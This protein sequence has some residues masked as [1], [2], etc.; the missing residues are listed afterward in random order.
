MPQLILPLIPLGGTE[1]SELVNI[2]REE[3]I[4]TYFVS[5]QPIFSH[6]ADDT[7]MFRLITSQLIDSG[8]C[9]Q[10]DILN[11]FGISKSSVDRSLKTLREKGADAFF[12]SRQRRRGGTKLTRNVLEQAQIFLDQGRSRQEIADHLGIKND[13]LRKAIHDGRLHKQEH[14]A[15]A[16]TKS[17]RNRV[18]AVA[19]DGMGTACTRV[20]ERVYASF[21][22][23]DGAPV[24]FESCLDVPNG[25]VMCA[26]P[27]LLVNGLLDGVERLSDKIKGYYTTFHILLLLAFMA[28]CRIKTV[29]KLKRQAPGEFG[30]LLGLDRIP[31]VRCL[32]QKL[33]DLSDGQAVEKW[34][35][36][37]S[38]YWMES[39]PETVG[40]L[41]IDGHVRVYHGGL[42]KLPRRF[43]SRQRLCLRGTTDYWV[44]DCLGKPFFVVEKPIDPGLI[45][46]LTT[47]IVPRLLEDVPEQPTSEALEAS[48]CL[49]RFIMV[50]DREG[51]SP[52]FFRQM[53]EEHRIACITY[54][55]HPTDSWPEEW[56]N[57]YE[58]T[59]PG[60]ETVSMNL[61]EMGCLIG[62]STKNIWMR[63]VR[64]LTESGHQTSL[65]STAYE[66]PHTELAARMFSRWC[67]ENFF[68]YMKQH[69]GIDKLSEYGVMEL[70][71]TEKVIN[72]AWRELNRKRNTIS[73]KLRYRRAH[74]AEMTMH[75]EVEDNTVQYQKWLN[76]KA[77][78]LEQIE[79]YE[80]Q[81]GRVKADMKDIPKH[82]AW[83]ELEEKDRFHRLLPG[84]K[85][86][87]DTL[88]MIAYRAET[89]MASLLIGPTVD[90]SAARCLLQDL[91]VTEADILPEPEA[92]LLK[93]RIHNASRPAANRA[94]LRLID[95]L[96]TAEVEYPGTGMRLYYELGGNILNESLSQKG[97]IKDSQ[98]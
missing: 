55:K 91:F 60:G 47:D 22:V 89:A 27:A 15:P 32:R 58:V 98:R 59:M 81:S 75:P 53:W 87:V 64:K 88:H 6:K 25:G 18:D 96:N 44:N 65:I 46:T 16:T 2:Y 95:K 49:C 19:A 43:V 62:S 3:N 11:V 34:A 7:K 13:T 20:E 66:L 97:V 38:R 1:I 56:F 30:K 10:K 71:D 40:T 17:S 70:P 82:I 67:Q 93:I 24:R 12:T 74:F 54:H 31:E 52:D 79:Q 50:F 37:L 4:W 41:Y 28:L 35:A 69:F 86:L 48:P 39:E 72:P 76:Q 63:E 45:K 61:A 57:K 23:C 84:R 73:N 9:R 26:L 90:L 68:R 85:R 14:S 42:T 29:E 5:L 21:G 33:D 77:E 51:Y 94:L 92:G 80:K 78:L 8:A 36:A 83:G